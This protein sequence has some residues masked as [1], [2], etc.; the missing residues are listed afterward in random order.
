[1]DFKLDAFWIGLGGGG[2]G[3]SSEGGTGLAGVRIEVGISRS[4]SRGWSSW[5]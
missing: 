2:G 5:N 3:E 4:V 1:M